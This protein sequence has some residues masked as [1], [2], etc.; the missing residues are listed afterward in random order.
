MFKKI[1]VAFDESAE[2]GRAFRS[3]LELAKLTSSELTIITVIERLPAYVSYVSAV[4]PDVPQI[5]Q[6]EKQTFYK[7][8]HHKASQMAE[9]SGV[10]LSF[11]TIEGDEIEGLLALIDDVQ[12]DL[13][14]IGLRREPGGFSG[15]IGGTAHRL[16]LHAK[17]DI[18]GIR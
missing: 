15:F 12:P 2:A 4:A 6:R 9:Q 8:L 1:A 7:E 3:A 16:A 18:L 14:V 13:L 5:L 10:G 11:A 17:C